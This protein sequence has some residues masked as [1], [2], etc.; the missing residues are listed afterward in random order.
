MLLLVL[1]SLVLVYMKN[2]S[3][4]IMLLLLRAILIQRGSGAFVI[5]TTTRRT[6][7]QTYPSYYV[8]NIDIPSTSS[9]PPSSSSSSSSSSSFRRPTS[10]LYG[11]RTF[12][13]N[14]LFSS[15]SRTKNKKKTKP[16]EVDKDRDSSG[17]C[18]D[19]VVVDGGGGDYNYHYFDHKTVMIPHDDKK[20]RGGEDAVAA[21]D[22]FLIVADGVGGWA[23][24]GVNPAAFARTLVN[25]ILKLSTMATT[26]TTTTN[27]T[28]NENA[29]DDDDDL[30]TLVHTANLLTASKH[31]GSATCTTLKLLGKEAS[32][33]GTVTL[34]ALNVGDSG[35]A[36]FRLRPQ[37]ESSSTSS[38]SSLSDYNYELIFVSQVGQKQFNF[39]HQLGGTR[40]GDDVRRVGI[41]AT[42]SLQTDDIVV[43]YSDGV[44]DNLPP[45]LFPKCLQQNTILVDDDSNTTSTTTTTTMNTANTTN[46]VVDL[47][48][49]ADCIARTAYFL[50]KDQSFDSPFAQGAREAGWGDCM[51][52]KHDDITVTI[53]QIRSGSKPPVSNDNKEES[54]LMYL[55]KVKPL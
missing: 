3:L 18:G 28:D 19:E 8:R 40:F 48:G 26:N 9:S 50:G 24:E 52:G 2:K 49:V 16:S 32:T 33:N 51:G 10:E 34:K 1:V 43:V 7:A 54:I 15:V 6:M 35:Y 44:S 23:S 39:P 37:S 25:T 38:S 17:G 42:H 22:Q 47:E 36:I 27:T 21:N 55:G 41:E 13:K 30:K 29:G 4:A 45:D 46:A 11:V 20:K 14:R 53:A 5:P 12:L 31:L